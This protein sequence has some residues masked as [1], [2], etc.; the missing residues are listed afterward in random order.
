MEFLTNNPKCNLRFDLLTWDIY[1]VFIT[2]EGNF[3]GA[4]GFELVEPQMGSLVVV[5]MAYRATTEWNG[6]SSY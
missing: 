5:S 2:L 4:S 3:K 6:L 1:W